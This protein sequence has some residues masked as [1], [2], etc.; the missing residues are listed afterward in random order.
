ME[1]KIILSVV[2]LLFLSACAS[3]LPKKETIV[4]KN[5]IALNTGN[6]PVRIKPATI[7]QNYKPADAIPTGMFIITDLSAKSAPPVKADKTGRSV[8]S[9]KILKKKIK[10]ALPE[11][12][13]NKPIVQQGTVLTK[14]KNSMKKQ[15]TKILTIYFDFNSSIIPKNERTKLNKFT[16]EFHKPVRIDGYAS[17][18]GSTAYNQALSLK[19]AMAVEKYLINQGVQVTTVIGRGEIEAPQSKLSRKA[20]VFIKRKGEC[21]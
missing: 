7:T 6:A 17:P 13:E 10:A 16:K 20:V 9:S 12:I 8:F 1:N 15:K 5:Y 3:I 11:K 21:L 2:L 14:T 19:R 4:P 18:S